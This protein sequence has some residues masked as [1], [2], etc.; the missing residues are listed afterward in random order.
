MPGDHRPV[1]V[2]CRGHSLAEA[3]AAGLRLQ[4]WLPQLAEPGARSPA[5]SQPVLLV[6]DDWGGLP[7]AAVAEATRAAG[8][9]PRAVVAVAGP[10]AIAELARVVAAGATA[11]NADQ[12][13]RRL[14]A[15]VQEAISA[16][17]ATPAQRARQLADLRLRME[18]ARRFHALTARECAVLAEIAV[19]RSAEVIAASRPVG[20]ATVRSQIAAVLRKLDVR[21]Q[22][23]AIALTCRSCADSRIVEPLAR[24]HQNYG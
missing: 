1:V 17:P 24:F 11:V 2:V 9:I 18:E 6:Q 4:G 16:G 3:L 23:A 15:S 14:L 10:S 7:R 8:L 13:W 5:G 12:P 19:G 21:S 22:P 20:L